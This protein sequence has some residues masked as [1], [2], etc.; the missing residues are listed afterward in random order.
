MD[1]PEEKA[2]EKNMEQ[3]LLRVLGYVGAFFFLSC[4]WC[5]SQCVI[6]AQAEQ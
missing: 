4:L 2:P 1:T 5:G 6:Y 3:K